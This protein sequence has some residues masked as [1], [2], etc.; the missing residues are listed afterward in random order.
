M[1]LVLVT[2]RVSQALC[3]YLHLIS[4]LQPRALDVIDKVSDKLSRCCRWSIVTSFAANQ[5][6]FFEKFV[7]AMI[8]MSQLSVLTGKQGEIRAS[9]SVRNSGSSYLESVVEEGLDALS[10]LI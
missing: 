7:V 9:C 2:Q 10:G 5:S 1:V 8:K 6:L 4:V 3:L